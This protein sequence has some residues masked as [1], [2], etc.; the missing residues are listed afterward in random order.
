MIMGR[1]SSALT[2]GIHDNV[3]IVD[4]RTM[5]RCPLLESISSKIIMNQS[6]EQFA[7]FIVLFSSHSA[8]SVKIWCQIK[9]HLNNSLL[10]KHFK[11]YSFAGTLISTE[12]RSRN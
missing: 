8:R 2:L 5:G 6:S 1:V 7:I 12:N 10:S 9:F 4:G 3:V 11:T